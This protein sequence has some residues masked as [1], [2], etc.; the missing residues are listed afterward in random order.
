MLFLNNIF[1]QNF[2]LIDIIYCIP[3]TST[4]GEVKMKCSLERVQKEWVKF[5]TGAGTFSEAWSWYFLDEF[6]NLADVLVDLCLMTRRLFGLRK[7]VSNSFSVLP[8][9][10]PKNTEWARF[11]NNTSRFTLLRSLF[12]KALYY[13][14]QNWGF[15]MVK[16]FE[17]CR[18]NRTFWN[19]LHHCGDRTE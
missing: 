5:R 9:D 3:D 14:V 17:A 12:P 1:F 16:S 13:I 15:D 8:E 18:W 10:C 2:S 7:I 6:H 4:N 11:R 19:I